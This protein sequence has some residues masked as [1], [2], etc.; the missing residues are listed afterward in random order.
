MTNIENNKISHVPA[1]RIEEF[2][3]RILMAAGMSEE[4]AVITASHLSMATLRGVESHGFGRFLM[5]SKRVS[6]GGMVSPTSVCMVHD[7]GSVIS[8]DGKNGVGQVV[9]Q[10]S[11]E[12]AIER[13]KETGI[14]FVTVK[15]SNHMG[16]LAPYVLLA[17]NNDCIGLAFTN[18]SPRMAPVGGAQAMLGNNPWSIAVPTGTNPIVM[19]MANSVAALGKVRILQARGELLPEGWARDSE[20]MP[21]RDPLAAITGLL[22]PIAGYKGY[23]IALMMELLTGA[24]SGG[25]GSYTVS[26][27]TNSGVA[28][29]VSH[30]FIAISLEKLGSKSDFLANVD[31][32]ASDVR[33]SKL[34]RDRS[35]ILMPGDIEYRNQISRKKMGI[36]L[37]PELVK[38][39][40]DAAEL[41]F[42]PIP[43]WLQ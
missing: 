18:A 15:N 24:A 20:G 2:G 21:T 43:E 3:K 12:M 31:K 11:M 1:E 8:L 6:E 25:G 28:G 37:E 33:N 4:D 5:Y 38:N 19:D 10:K 16:A 40:R 23:V 41:F 13:A 30:S 7:G 22:E 26:A 35:E 9:A 17:A 34:A 29:N 14:C 32:L 39:L 42:V 36:P 27:V